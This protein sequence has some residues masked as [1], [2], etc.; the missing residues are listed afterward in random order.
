[1][2]SEVDL[3][4]DD[5]EAFRA[6]SHKALDGMIDHLR[7]VRTRPVWRQPTEEAQR[8]LPARASFGGA[9]LCRGARGF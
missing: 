6:E 4:P 2:T 8:P 5:W 3:D 7:D 1:M 9:R